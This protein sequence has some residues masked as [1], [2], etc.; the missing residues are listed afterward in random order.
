ME[1]IPEE[2][3]NIEDILEN[4]DRCV[5]NTA[6]TVGTGNYTVVSQL[7]E[8]TFGSVCL[9][10][11]NTTNELFAVKRILYGTQLQVSEIFVPLAFRHP[12]MLSATHA[13]I[14]EHYINIVYPVMVTDLSSLLDDSDQFKRIRNETKVRWLYEI[15]SALLFLQTWGLYHLDLKP[16]NILL[17]RMNGN[18]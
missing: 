15:V 8:G 12:D 11:D 9:V 16:R 14:D 6:V 10:R 4:A 1:P 2:N 3:E 5:E 13:N 18:G 7:G 17:G